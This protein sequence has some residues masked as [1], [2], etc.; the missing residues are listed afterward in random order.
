MCFIIV[1]SNYVC[2]SERLL[3]GIGQMKQLIRARFLS[4]PADIPDMAKHADK[5]LKAATSKLVEFKLK[6]DIFV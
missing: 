6:T 1:M 2:I 5:I 3:G 4:D